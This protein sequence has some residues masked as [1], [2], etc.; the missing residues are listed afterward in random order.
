MEKRLCVFVISANPHQ[1][2]DG[3]GHETEQ[4][5][6][7]G[8]REEQDKKRIREKQTSILT[9]IKTHLESKLDSREQLPQQQ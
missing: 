4:D 7:E 1:Q 6:W 3:E 2:D 9:Q 5:S 8:G